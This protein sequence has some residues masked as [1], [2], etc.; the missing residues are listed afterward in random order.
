MYCCLY[1]AVE[2]AA[3]VAEDA[4]VGAEEVEDNDD[5]IIIAND[6]FWAFF[7]H[8]DACDLVQRR[9]RTRGAGY[10]VAEDLVQRAVERSEQTTGR[11]SD[12]CVTVA[13][14]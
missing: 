3:V 4:L 9:M 7:D 1:V 10:D 8:Q 12:F 5:F 14:F 2:G 11:H 6:A 13:F